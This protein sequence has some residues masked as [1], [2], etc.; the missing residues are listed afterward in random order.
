MVLKVKDSIYSQS[1]PPCCS[2][3]Q[4]QQP[5]SLLHSWVSAIP[6]GASLFI[7]AEAVTTSEADKH[8][9]LAQL[10]LFFTISLTF[11][12]Y[13]EQMLHNRSDFHLG[14]PAGLPHNSLH[15]LHQ[16]PWVLQGKWV[17]PGLPGGQGLQAV[18]IPARFR[19]L[20]DGLGAHNNVGWRDFGWAC[21]FDFEDCPLHFLTT[22][23]HKVRAPLGLLF[24]SKN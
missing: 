23:L 12:K 3:Q 4:V 7:I 19:C 24:M 6:P 17:K 22:C 11:S 20:P 13:L 9:K 14:S 10:F 5:V 16:G 15:L 21:L 18:N 8:G 2:P 1:P